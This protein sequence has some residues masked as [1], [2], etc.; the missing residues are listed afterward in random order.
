M[1]LF[2]Y[3]RLSYVSDALARTPFFCKLNAVALLDMSLLIHTC[4]HG[5]QG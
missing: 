3:G 2:F 1:Q 5:F 4:N